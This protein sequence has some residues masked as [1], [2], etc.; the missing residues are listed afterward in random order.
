MNEKTRF[1]YL[2]MV[3]FCMIGVLI[4]ALLITGT[5]RLKNRRI[6]TE[7]EKAELTTK[8][9]AMH[10]EIY[11]TADKQVGDYLYVVGAKGLEIRMT[12]CERKLWRVEGILNEQNKKKEEQR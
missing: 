3:F 5:N 7:Q 10:S 8:V 6:K 4:G 1:D 9:N 12:D 2:M 11:G